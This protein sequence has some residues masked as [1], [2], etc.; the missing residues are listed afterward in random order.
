MTLLLRYP[1]ADNKEEDMKDYVIHPRFTTRLG[2]GTLFILDPLDDVHFTHECHFEFAFAD[3]VGM[4]V[5]IAM[6]HCQR[7][8]HF[9]TA[10]GGKRQISVDPQTVATQAKARKMRR[11]KKA[12]NDRRRYLASMF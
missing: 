7:I 4:R 1:H 2:P 8:H 6:R 9:R 5:A 3:E 11:A 12:A 10:P